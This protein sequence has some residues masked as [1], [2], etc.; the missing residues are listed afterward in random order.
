[1]SEGENGFIAKSASAED[2]A[3]AIL[4]VHG[5]G[6]ALRDSTAASFTRRAE[7]VSLER[8]LNIVLGAYRARSTG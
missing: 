4:C 5:A 6:Q 8:S 3:A 2:L 7:S 1:V